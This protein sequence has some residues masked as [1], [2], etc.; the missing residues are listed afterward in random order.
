MGRLCVLAIILLASPT[1]PREVLVLESSTFPVTLPTVGALDV[2]TCA[3]LNATAADLCTR[4]GIAAV[5]IAPELDVWNYT[6]SATRAS[7]VAASSVLRALLSPN[8]TTVVSV[9]GVSL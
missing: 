1:L 2:A 3:D 7:T 6:R 5:G 9:C 8:N 4:E